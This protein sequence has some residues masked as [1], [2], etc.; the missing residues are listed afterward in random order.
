MSTNSAEPPV[1]PIS[2]SETEANWLAWITSIAAYANSLV[3]KGL[4][5]NT[6]AW[7]PED[8]GA[9]P[10]TGDN[11]NALTAWFN[12]VVS[13]GIPGH[14]PANSYPCAS[15][16]TWDLTSAAAKGV[17]IFGAG[18]GKSIISLSTS[19]SPALLIGGTTT[20]SNH[21]FSGFSV[22]GS[23]A[24]SIV[25]LGHQDYSDSLN[26]CTF[27]IAVTNSLSNSGASEPIAGRGT[28]LERA[29][30]L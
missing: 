10:N 19:S 12:A 17:R 20:L 2:P 24:G 18:M 21:V 28:F 29:W 4:L 27:D 3:S 30:C 13:T 11:S 8:F 23:V 5:R 14:I 9:T 22:T 7:I 15:Q 25:Q 1:Q 16:L 26:A 6:I